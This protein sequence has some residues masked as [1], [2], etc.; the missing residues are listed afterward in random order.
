[1]YLVCDPL[2]NCTLCSD[3]EVDRRRL[4]VLSTA[5]AE[6]EVQRLR[7]STR[8]CGLFFGGGL[9]MGRGRRTKRTMVASWA[10]RG[11]IVL[12]FWFLFSFLIVVPSYLLVHSIC[13]KKLD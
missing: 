8:L 4:H 11:V 1:M 13:T 9:V 6:A 10:R 7:E 2:E 12:C 5:Q 3:S